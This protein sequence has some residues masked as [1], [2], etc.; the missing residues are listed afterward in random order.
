[1]IFTLLYNNF[2]VID[3]SLE[4]LKKTTVLDL[5]IMAMD[6]HYPLITEEE[7]NILIKKYNLIVLDEGENLGLSAGFNMLVNTFDCKTAIFYDIDSFPVTHGWDAAM[8]SS[9]E[10]KRL[11]F[12][13]LY[14]DIAKRELSERGCVEWVNANGLTMLQPKQAGVQSVSAANIEYLKSIGGLQ[15]P[16]KYYGGFEIQMFNYW[17]DEHRISYIKDYYEDKEYFNNL[18]DPQYTAYKFAYAHNGYK[19]SFD[20]FLKL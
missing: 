5:P 16:R 10:D 20:D 7:K 18:V 17:N 4:Q 8:M 12:C 1:M 19:G 15:E 14:F 13:S 2:N 6:N 11:A 3:K 9:L